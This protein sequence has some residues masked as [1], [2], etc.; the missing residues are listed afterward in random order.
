[1]RIFACA[2]G[3]AVGVLAGPASAD[4]LPAPEGPVVLTVRADG[5]TAEFDL[6][7]LQSLP[8]VTIETSTDWT[9]GVGSF[10]GP[11][12]RDVLEAA[13]VDGEVVVA[14]AL[15]DYEIEIPAAD[16]ETYDVI[17]ALQLDGTPLSR[18]DKGPIWVVYPRDQHV[19][20]QSAEYNARW[21]WQLRH[22]V[23]E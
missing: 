5:T 12:A 17:M 6:A 11:L 3:L 16:F 13:G 8:Q 20:L 21:I 15:N 14:R 23:V 10:A 19:D 9:D 2:F 7:M 4:R 1:M 18:R 22:V